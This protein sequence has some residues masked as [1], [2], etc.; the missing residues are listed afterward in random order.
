MERK[1]IRETRKIKRIM[2]DKK[3]KAVGHGV[4]GWVRGGLA[5]FR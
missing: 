3:G 1:E 4:G 5:Q 2:K